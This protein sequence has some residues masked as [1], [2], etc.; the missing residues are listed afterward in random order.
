[1]HLRSPFGHCGKSFPDQCIEENPDATAP[2]LR[3]L[4]W[5]AVRDEP[6]VMKAMIREIA[7]TGIGAGA[8]GW[9]VAGGSRAREV[10]A[11]HPRMATFP[12]FR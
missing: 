7:L 2:E 5:N 4:L 8:C 6:K 10:M 12:C 9:V 3:Q 11:A 1:L